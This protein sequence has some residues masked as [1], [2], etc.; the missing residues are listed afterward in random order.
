MDTVQG[1]HD[2]RRGLKHWLPNLDRLGEPQ[3]FQ[4]KLRSHLNVLPFTCSSFE[5]GL[6]K[7]GEHGGTCTKRSSAFKPSQRLIEKRKARRSTADLSTRKQLSFEIQRVHRQELRAWKSAQISQ[8]FFGGGYLQNPCMWKRLR[9]L[10]KHPVRTITAP[11]HPN[12]FADMLETFFFVFFLRAFLTAERS[13]ARTVLLVSLQAFG[14]MLAIY[15]P[16]APGCAEE[17]AKSKPVSLQKGWKSAVVGGA[18]DF[19]EDLTDGRGIA[20]EVVAAR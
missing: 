4:T 20:F 18:G 2:R 12:D 8:H 15:I 9:S 19:S 3:A 13:V 10:E 6:V 14:T 17:R 11:P 1:V 16:A 5:A 7:A